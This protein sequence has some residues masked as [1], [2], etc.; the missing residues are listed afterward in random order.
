M[1]EGLHLAAML[2]FAAL[3]AYALFEAW[4]RRPP[5]L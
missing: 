3:I 1:K 2:A 5:R 4:V